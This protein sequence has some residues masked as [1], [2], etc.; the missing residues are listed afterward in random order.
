MFFRIL[1]G[2]KVFFTIPFLH[3]YYGK[4]KQKN[5]IKNDHDEY[6]DYFRYTHQGLELLFK[7]LK[8]VEIQ[9]LNGPVEM[10]ITNLRLYKFLKNPINRKLVDLIDFSKV[11]KQT[12]RHLTYCIK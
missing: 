9:L 8:N 11:S 10:L 4:T 2:G 7:D 12:S 3:G 6:P 1:T 5:S